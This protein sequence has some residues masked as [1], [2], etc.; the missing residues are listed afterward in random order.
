MLHGLPDLGFPG[1]ILRRESAEFNHWTGEF[2][3]L[4]ILWNH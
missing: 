4:P 3:V 1:W 2:L